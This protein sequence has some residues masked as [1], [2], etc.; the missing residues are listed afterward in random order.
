MAIQIPVLGYGTGTT[1]FKDT[2][3]I[4]DAIALGSFHLDNAGLCGTLESQIE[5]TFK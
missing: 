3:H 2:A 5:M 1:V 4:K